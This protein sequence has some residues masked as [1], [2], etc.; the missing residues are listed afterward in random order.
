[1][2]LTTCDV[3]FWDWTR[4]R[5]GLVDV[6]GWHNRIDI[7]AVEAGEIVDESDERLNA[8]LQ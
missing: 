1:M 3:K 2:A 8:T 7:E 5:G 4:K 6:C